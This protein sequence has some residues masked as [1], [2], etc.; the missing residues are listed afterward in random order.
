MTNYEEMNESWNMFRRKIDEKVLLL[1]NEKKNLEIERRKKESIRKTISLGKDN[2]EYLINNGQILINI[3]NKLS[4]LFNAL[5][6][7]KDNKKLDNSAVPLIVDEIIKS[8]KINNIF[9]EIK[10]LIDKIQALE[11]QIN[12]ITS[13]KNNNYNKELIY[14]LFDEFGLDEINKRRIIMY[15]I[16]SLSK[17]VKVKKENKVKI[18]KEVKAQKEIKEDEPIL[19]SP[20]LEYNEELEDEV[21]NKKKSKIKNRSVIDEYSRNYKRYKEINEQYKDIIKKYT[22]KYKRLPKDVLEGYQIDVKNAEEFDKELYRKYSIVLTEYILD[23]KGSIEEYKNIP[24]N[25]IDE[26]DVEFLFQTIV[27]YEDALK[28][29]KEL[30]LLEENYT[31]EEVTKEEVQDNDLNAIDLIDEEEKEEKDNSGIDYEYVSDKYNQIKKEF[32]SIL[33]KYSVFS[34]T[35]EPERNLLKTYKQAIKDGITLNMN[36]YEVYAKCEATEVFESKKYIDEY[37]AELRSGNES[38]YKYLDQV[39]DEF[40]DSL[41]NLREYDKA[42][43]SSI[44]PNEEESKSNNVFFLLDN[45]NKIVVPNYSDYTD[46]Y[47]L[48]SRREIDSENHDTLFPDIKDFEGRSVCAKKIGKKVFSYIIVPYNEGVKG[49]ALLVLTATHLK[50]GY[51]KLKIESAK[52]LSEY[53][54]EEL[55]QASLIASSDKD[56]LKLEEEAKDKLNG[57]SKEAKI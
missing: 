27:K 37:F 1:R 53:S 52:V 50:D 33:K 17:E 47:K 40:S 23:L 12:E 32:S 39:L 56:Y 46:V 21:V 54:N 43:I 24:N 22:N 11:L 30:S 51:D 34:N 4:D 42:Y 19:A 14:S 36:E 15:M 3:D 9:E 20:I 18:Q 44:T 5:K 25:K 6:Y 8:P 31:F 38:D 29:L 10:A 26:T 16:T 13:I 2:I 7:F 41:S 28:D 35:T 55:N 57:L 49:K 48:I 45:E